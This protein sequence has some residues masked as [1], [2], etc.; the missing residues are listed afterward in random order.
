[1]DFIL[2]EKLTLISTLITF[3]AT[4][5][6][7]FIKAGNLQYAIVLGFITIILFLIFI[8]TKSTKKKKNMENHKIWSE[9]KYWKN[10]KIKRLKLCNPLRE[11]L[12]KVCVTILVEIVEIKLKKFISEK[13]KMTRNN[14]KT[15][16]NEIIDGYEGHWRKNLVP[17]IF[18]EKFYEF[19]KVKINELNHFMDFIIDSKLYDEDE[20][21]LAMID[22]FNVVI[23][24]IIL[25]LE[26]TN[27]SINGELTKQL[28]RLREQGEF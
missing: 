10:Q 25:D 26:K 3:I 13:T 6:T 18:I 20:K 24:W 8:L 16:F 14:I 9:M 2:K 23:N 15:L 5:T 27:D 11:K 4:I 1:M 21:L 19:N 7:A 22:H 12:L 17:E 28:K